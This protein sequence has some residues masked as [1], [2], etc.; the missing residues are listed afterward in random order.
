MNLWH[1]LWLFGEKILPDTNGS[2]ELQ[3]IRIRG[4]F[5]RKC[6]MEIY[7]ADECNQEH[8]TKNCNDQTNTDTNC[9]L[10]RNGN[11]KKLN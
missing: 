8:V 5:P 2:T 9:D 6:A 4:W 11:A 3:K 7:E 1:R 10:N